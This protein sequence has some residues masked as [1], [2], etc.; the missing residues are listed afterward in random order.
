M[1]KEKLLSNIPFAATK[2]QERAIDVISQFIFDK[3]IP[4]FILKG[5]AGTGKTTIMAAL[6]KT[7]PL[8]KINTVLLAPTGRAAKVLSLYSDKN[9]FTIHKRIYFSHHEDN[10]FSF[11]LKDN[12]SKDTIFIVDE[13]SMIGIKQDNMFTSTNL[14][15]RP[16]AVCKKWNKL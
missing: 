2:D 9:A 5:Y 7:L 11:K 12:K 13:A 8:F 6:V 1:F 16:Y 10:E 14:F 15:G 4:I 3:N